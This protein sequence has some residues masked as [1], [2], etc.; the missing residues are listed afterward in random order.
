MYIPLPEEDSALGEEGEDLISENLETNLEI[1]FW[2]PWAGEMAEIIDELITEYNSENPWLNQI[3]SRSHADQDVLIEDLT[4]SFEIGEAIPD[5]IVSSSQ[6]L[7]TWY[8]DG[9]SIMELDALLELLIGETGG[10]E[11]AQIF[12]VFWNVDMVNGKRIGIPAYQS[13][14]FLFYNQTW[15]EELGFLD[16]PKNTEE[17]R[18]Q[19]CLAERSNRFDNE[20]EN[21]GTGGWF[22][23][24][25][26]LSLLAWLRVFDGGELVNSRFQPI[27][28]EPENIEALRFLHDLYQDNCAWWTPKQQRPYTYFSKRFTLIYSGQMEDMIRQ[29]QIDE[30]TGNPDDRKLIPYPSSLGKPVVMVKG[31]SFA[32]STQD[33]ARAVAALDFVNWMLQPENQAK[34]IEKTGVFP[35]SNATIEFVRNDIPFYPIW[36]ESLQYLPFAQPEPVFKEWYAM[37]KVLEDVGWQLIQFSMQPENI[38]GVLSDAERIL[39]EVKDLGE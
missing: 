37:E 4:A 7:Q 1:E 28:A 38:E 39:V 6:S 29:L 26:S 10:R 21:N 33:E 14:Q 36:R 22:Y 11:L 9:Y 13:G 2:H 12:P 8:S 17:F 25:E 32:I 23:S 19:T 35:M 16:Y 27:L 15:G 31:L 34:I 24:R 3:I 20:I 18:E 5:L 30:T